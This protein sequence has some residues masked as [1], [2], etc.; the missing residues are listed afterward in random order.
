MVD[1]LNW[2]RRYEE[3]DVLD[4]TQREVEIIRKNRNLKRSGSNKLPAEWEIS[5]EL[6]R[7]ISDLKFE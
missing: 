7:T 1:L 5:C 4:G 6:I 3:P 2:K